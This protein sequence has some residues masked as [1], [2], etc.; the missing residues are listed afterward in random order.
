MNIYLLRHG[1]TDWNCEGRL[2]GH[3]DVWMN[4]K[5]IAQIENA[6]EA[7][8]GLAVTLDAIITSP[9]VR[10]RKSA[11]IVADKTGYQKDKI[12]IDP[13]YIERSFGLGEGL[14]VEERRQKYM[15]DTYPEMESMILLLERAKAA[16]HNTINRYH[17]ENNILIAAHGAILKAVITS[18]T[19][20]KIVYKADNVQIEPGSIHM[21]QYQ[22][23]TIGLFKYSFTEQTFFEIHF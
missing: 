4:R 22:K 14:T 21:I 18:F 10:A 17:K 19:E 7:L 12:V 13:L 16:F 23:N 15:D 8:A 2:Q 11:E 1:E 20:G 3:E 5:G 6:A 9:L